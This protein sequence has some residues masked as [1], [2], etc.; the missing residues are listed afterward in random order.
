M[1]A[2]RGSCVVVVDGRRSLGI[3]TERDMVR[4]FLNGESN[5]TLDVIMTRPAIS[6]R[7]DCPLTDAAQL[8]FDHGIRHLIVVNQSGRAGRPA[9]RTHPDAPAQG[10][11]A[12][13]KP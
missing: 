6:I 11:P 12:S 3:V 13:T 9:L 8:M 7:A 5:P 10:R 4:L 2:V 1:E